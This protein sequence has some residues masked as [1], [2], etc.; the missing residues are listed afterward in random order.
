LSNVRSVHCDRIPGLDATAYATFPK[1]MEVLS[2]RDASD[3]APE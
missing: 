1:A 2:S 3:I